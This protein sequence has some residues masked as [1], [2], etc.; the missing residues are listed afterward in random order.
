MERKPWYQLKWESLQQEKIG[1]KEKQNKEVMKT[2]LD[3]LEEKLDDSQVKL[4]AYQKM[5]ERYFKSKV[6]KKSSKVGNLVLIKN[7]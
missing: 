3:L 4:I 2:K 1:Y 6:S 5:M 7:I